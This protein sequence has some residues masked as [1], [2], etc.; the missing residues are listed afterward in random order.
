MKEIEILEG[1]KNIE[2]DKIIQLPTNFITVGEVE[3]DD[4]KIYIKQG[5]YNEIEKILKEGYIT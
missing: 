1:E 4:V 3:V 5:V 2:D